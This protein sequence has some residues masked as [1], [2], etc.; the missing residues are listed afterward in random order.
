MASAPHAGPTEVGGAILT[1][2]T[3]VHASCRWLRGIW[4]RCPPT[5]RLNDAKVLN[6]LK[7]AE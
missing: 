6:D 3:N 7:G 1:G 2:G 5:G 4:Q